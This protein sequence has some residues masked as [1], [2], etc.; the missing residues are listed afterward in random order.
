MK[1]TPA[2]INEVEMTLEEYLRNTLP[3]SHLARIEYENL[4]AWKDTL[5][6]EVAEAQKQINLLITVARAADALCK[7]KI[8]D[9]TTSTPRDEWFIKWGSVS[10]ALKAAREGGFEI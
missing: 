2:T 5:F 10:E 3:A 6:G 9:M 8:K 1:D 7:L 4:V